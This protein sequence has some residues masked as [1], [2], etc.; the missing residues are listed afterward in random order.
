MKGEEDL[1]ITFRLFAPY[2]RKLL[3][4]ARAAGVGHNHFARIATMAAVDHD[5]FGNHEKL[6]RIEDELLRLRME[7]NDALE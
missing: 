4:V 5:L 2:G 3:D 1:K 6:R 7:F